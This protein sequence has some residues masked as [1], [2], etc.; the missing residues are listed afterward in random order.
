MHKHQIDLIALQETKVNHSSEEIKQLPPYND[1]Y[2]F[3]F[4]SSIN[5][6]QPNRPPPLPKTNAKAKQASHYVEHHGVGF[7]IGP[8][9]ISSVK[10]CVPHNSRLIEIKF[11]NH[12]PDLNFI[13]H[14]APHSGRPY[15]EKTRHWENLQRILSEHPH[16]NPTYIL[17]DANA[18][19]HGCSTDV[20]RLCI[21]YRILCVWPWCPAYTKPVRRA[22]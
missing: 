3:Y 9:L 2:L 18:R 21:G 11:H 10:D 13:N 14:Y 6:T 19:L 4:S 5:K 7:A 20:E 1:R 12:G 15:E 22:T 8:R 16:A 17:G